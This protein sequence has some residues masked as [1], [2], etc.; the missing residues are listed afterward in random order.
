MLAFEKIT[1]KDI[2]IAKIYESETSN[3]VVQEIYYTPKFEGESEII[4]DD[5]LSLLEEEKVRIQK[6]H[7]LTLA[8][9]RQICED[10]KKTKT[11]NIWVSG[12]D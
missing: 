4:S 1:E 9:Y 3:K 2:L 7:N 5:I 12:F 6:D 10:I 11:V 8:E